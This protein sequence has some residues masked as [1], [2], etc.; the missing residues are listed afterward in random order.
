MNDVP[1]LLRNDSEQ[2]G[3]FLSIRLA[4]KKSNRSGIG[5]R[6]KVR[7]GKREL[8]QEVRS[9]S[10]FMSQSD[11]RLHFGLG[12]DKSADEVTVRWPSGAEQSVKNVEANQFV[13]IT[14]QE[15]ITDSKRA[16]AR[17]GR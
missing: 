12:A 1:S 8:V 17:S 14:E 13:T 7:L 16:P 2:L 15:G 6:V 9:G 5:A 3:G 10:T 11:L 4:G